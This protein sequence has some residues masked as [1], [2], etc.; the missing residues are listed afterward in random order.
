MSE[1]CTWT[2]SKL[3]KGLK[4]GDIT[5][6]EA[7]RSCLDA[8]SQKDKQIGAFL[9]VTGEQALARAAQIDQLRASGQVLPPLAGIPMAIKDNICT[10][11]V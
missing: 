9:T 11:G 4:D 5:S 2:I 8:I 6:A 10:Q 3:Q 7:V 1:L